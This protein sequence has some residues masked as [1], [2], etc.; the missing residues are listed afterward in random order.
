MR[1]LALLEQHY[2]TDDTI[3]AI[4]A[5]KAKLFPRFGISSI[6]DMML[7]NEVTVNVDMA[8]GDPMQRMQKFLMATNA[9]VQLTANAP[10]GANIKEMRKEIYS[11]A[12]YRDGDRFWNEQEDPRLMKAMQAIQQLQGQ[13]QGKQMEMQHEGQLEQMK[14]TSNEKIK[15]AQLQVDTGRITGD[16]RIREAELV[17]EQQRLELEKLQLQVDAQSN[18]EDRQAKRVELMAKVQEA[19]ARIEEAQ[20]DIQKA[21]MGIQEKSMEMSHSLMMMGHERE[22]ASREM[23]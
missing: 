13:L 12:G 20:M 22:L 3:L 23:Q 16:L 15:G 17:I 14:L 7:M 5:N 18:D 10:P 2:E 21:R 11:N 1:Q 19:Q 6:T 4:C 9:A 8:T